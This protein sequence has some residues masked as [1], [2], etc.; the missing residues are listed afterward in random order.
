MQ[1]TRQDTAHMPLHERC[2]FFSRW[3]KQIV[4]FALALTICVRMAAEIQKHHLLTR[5]H[6]Y[7]PATTDVA[8]AS[9]VL[10]SDWTGNVQE[11]TR[12]HSS[13]ETDFD[14]SHDYCQYYHPATGIARIT[15]TRWLAAQAVESGVWHGNQGGEDRNEQ[16][17]G[18][19]D[20][21]RSVNGS[22]LGRMLEIGC[23][24]F[25][26]T[27]TLLR[28]VQ[29]PPQEHAITSITLADPLMLFYHQHVPSCPYR[30]GSLLGHRTLFIASGAEDLALRGVYDTVIMMNVLEHCRDALAV[31]E[32]LHAAVKGGTGLLVFS[33]RWYDTKWRKYE[34]DR[35]PFWD[36]MHPINIKRAVI[37]TLLAQY[38]PLY[39]RDFHYE[40]DYPTDEGVYFIGIKKQDL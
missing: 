34:L 1:C 31:L 5:Q 37:E 15:Q 7:V 30:T 10:Y 27:Q 36:I 22:A 17:A 33:E 39:R 24:P 19:F 8:K 14:A 3:F 40:G 20:Q 28:K 9:S 26:Q 32:N 38:T 35:A 18:W 25:T 2:R 16:H 11:N 13:S 6:P 4:V 23:G 29:P 21:Y 12:C